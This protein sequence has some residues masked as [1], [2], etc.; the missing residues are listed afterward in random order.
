LDPDKGFMAASM[1]LKFIAVQKAVLFAGFRH[2]KPVGFKPWRKVRENERFLA[3]WGEL[4]FL[5]E[6]QTDVQ[7]T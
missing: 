5:L 6:P 1:C 2:F 4:H 3:G 7:T